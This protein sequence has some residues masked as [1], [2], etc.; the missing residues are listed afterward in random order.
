MFWGRRCS[1]KVG[2]ALGPESPPLPRRP[3]LVCVECKPVSTVGR[4]P[5]PL[6]SGGRLWFS[7][8][9]TESASFICAQV[10]VRALQAVQRRWGSC[11]VTEKAGEPRPG[12]AW[13]PFRHNCQTS[14]W[15]LAV[16]SARRGWFCCHAPVCVCVF[17]AA[18]PLC[19]ASRQDH[20]CWKVPPGPFLSETLFSAV[21]DAHTFVGFIHS[22]V[23]MAATCQTLAFSNEK[24]QQILPEG[25]LFL[26]VPMVARWE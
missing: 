14:P 3:V 9:R 13:D 11:H 1:A 12:S 4:G 2:W 6:H 23:L 25:N 18:A 5:A 26:G 16:P 8:P 15:G 21:H 24:K 17:P 20:L 10:E 19:L 7:G 22:C